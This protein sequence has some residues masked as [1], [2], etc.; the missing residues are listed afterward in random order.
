MILGANFEG[1]VE[2]RATTLARQK[3]VGFKKL[4]NHDAKFF[5]KRINVSGFGGESGN[6]TAGSDP[7][8]G[9][10]IPES[11]YYVRATFHS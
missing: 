6:V 10:C 9:L 11:V 7:N 2:A 4:W 5:D 1:N 8:F 3:S